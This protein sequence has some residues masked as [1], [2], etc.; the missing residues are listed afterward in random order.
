MPD[1][2]RN[3]QESWNSIRSCQTLSS[4]Q[5]TGW[6]DAADSVLSTRNQKRKWRNQKTRNQWKR[7]KAGPRTEADRMTESIGK[8]GTE[9]RERN[10]RKPRGEFKEDLKH[11]K[12]IGNNCELLG[13]D[14]EAFG[15][16][17][18]DKQHFWS[19]WRVIMTTADCSEFMVN[20]SGPPV[21]CFTAQSPISSRGGVPRITGSGSLCL[22][23]AVL[24]QSLT[25][26][27]RLIYLRHQQQK[28]WVRPWG[29]RKRKEQR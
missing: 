10:W 19:A 24:L 4:V 20:C 17:P 2:G 9:A 15:E 7:G 21:V 12:K 18:Q 14:R 27:S 29:N 5:R 28:R 26:T 3:I 22:Y 6:D 25:L 23:G 11:V 8:K 16:K 1:F 13:K